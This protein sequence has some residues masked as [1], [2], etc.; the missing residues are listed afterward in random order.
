MSTTGFDDRNVIGLFTAGYEAAF[1]ASWAKAVSL[2]NGNSDRAAEE[3][4][5][6]GG[7]P[8]MREWIGGR[9][10]QVHN[11]KTYEIRNKRYEATLVIPE[12]ELSRDKSGLLQARMDTFSAD[13]GAGHWEDLLVTLINANGTCYDGQAFYSATHSWGDSG[14]QKNLVTATEIPSANVGTPTAPTA[15][16]MANILLEAVGYM[17]TL[18]NDKGRPIN[19]TSKSWIVQVATAQLYSAVMQAIKLNKLAAGADNPLGGLGMTFEALLTP[20][21]TSA[22]SKIRLHRADPKGIKPFILQEEKALQLEVLGVG[23]DFFFDNKAIKMGVDS[24][25]GAGYGEPLYSLDVTLS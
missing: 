24:S 3:Y 8:A 17:M 23:S 18:K 22:T 21:L 16:E 20:T 12:L 7:N 14:T 10:A 9:L 13:A 1:A 4:G 15:T 11:K 6:L 2:F 19:G 25:R 5:I